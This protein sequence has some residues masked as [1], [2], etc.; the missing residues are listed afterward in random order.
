MTSMLARPAMAAVLLGSMTTTV[1][2][3]DVDEE[4]SRAE[5]FACEGLRQQLQDSLLE[6]EQAPIGLADPAVGRALDEDTDQ[7]CE[8]FDDVRRG[9]RGRRSRET[10]IER[11]R[12]GGANAAALSDGPEGSGHYWTVTVAVERDGKV[13][14]GCLPT[15]T[16][17]WRN[18]PRPKGTR[19]FGGWQLLVRGHLVVWTELSVGAAESESLIYP[20]VYALQGDALVVDRSQ[21]LAAIGRFGR[22]YARVA[23]LRG[24]GDRVMH[25]GAAAAYRAVAAGSA[26]PASNAGR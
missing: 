11:G 7:P 2:A 5:K 17:G 10:E 4:S 9:L 14:G 8:R 3:E 26:C 22:N 13:L 24:N 18:L 1:V 16:A 23:A 19:I 20:V 21:T 25:A 6:D 12:L 15:K